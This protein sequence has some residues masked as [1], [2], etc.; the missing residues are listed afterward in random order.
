MIVL[1]PF[2]EFFEGL[3]MRIIFWSLPFLLIVLPAIII[4]VFLSSIGT[5]KDKD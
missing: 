3:F 2:L 4:A 1:D 5:K